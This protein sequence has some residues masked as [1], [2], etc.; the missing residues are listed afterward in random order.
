MYINTYCSIL[1]N[2]SS[3]VEEEENVDFDNFHKRFARYRTRVKAE[4]NSFFNSVIDD[5]SSESSSLDD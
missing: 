1:G 2:S 5:S 4:E 3:E